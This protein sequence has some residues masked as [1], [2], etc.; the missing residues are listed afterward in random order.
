MSQPMREILTCNICN[1]NTV[2]NSDFAK[3]KLTAKHLRLVNPSKNSQ[4]VIKVYTCVCGK[5][6]KHD[7]SYYKHKKGCLLINT[8]E[9]DR[10]NPFVKVPEFENTIVY[11]NERLIIDNNLIIELLKQNQ[12]F[13]EMLV[14]QNNKLMEQNKQNQELNKQIIEIAKEHKTINTTNNNTNCNN[15]FNLNVFLNETCKDAI[16]LTD[17]IRDMNISLSELENVGT[18]GYVNGISDIIMNRLRDLEFNRRPLHCT[19]LKRE[20]MYIRED[21]AWKKDTKDNPNVKWMVDRVAS[22]NCN[23]ISEWREE[24]PDCKILDNQLYE[25]CLTIMIQSAGQLGE[26]QIRMDEKIMKNI[27][28]EVFVDKNI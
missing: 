16:N 9:G 5:S 21:N 1:Y 11:T 3:H 12:E 22:K 27:A 23:K 17:F 14:D 15:K 25:T 24:N 26:K 28:N 19:D 4:P 18:T 13:K 20:T 7:S 2:K 10:I 6:Y 8:P